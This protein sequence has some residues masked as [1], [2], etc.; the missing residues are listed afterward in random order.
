MDLTYEKEKT[1]LTPKENKKKTNTRNLFEQ[2]ALLQKTDGTKMK[3]M[4]R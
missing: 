4:F 3:T 2:A 1:T